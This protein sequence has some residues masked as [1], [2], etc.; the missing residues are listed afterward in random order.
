M[1]FKL[2]ID[3]GNDGM[4]SSFDVVGALKTIAGKISRDPTNKGICQWVVTDSN[5]NKVGAAEL[6]EYDVKALFTW[7]S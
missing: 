6:T 7:K 1:K 3:L 5:G 4:K 2:E